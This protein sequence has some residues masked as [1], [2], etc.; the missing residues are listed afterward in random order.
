MELLFKKTYYYTSNGNQ[1]HITIRLYKNTSFFRSYNYYLEEE[2]SWGKDIK[3]HY[4]DK[5][6]DYV[7]YVFNA[8]RYALFSD[9]NKAIYHIPDN[10]YIL[11]YGCS[12]GWAH[13][14]E[15]SFNIDTGDYWIKAT[16]GFDDVN[17]RRKWDEAIYNYTGRKYKSDITNF[18]L[19]LTKKV[20]KILTD[21]GTVVYSSNDSML[22]ASFLHRLPRIFK[23]K[24]L[25]SY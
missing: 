8:Y 5:E 3:K 23:V 19:T 25:E 1:E 17:Q 18:Y 22:C 24:E 7:Q 10:L 9:E 14:I 15:A 20:L 16:Q 21:D 11:L 12:W 2:K 6:S 13:F 4:L